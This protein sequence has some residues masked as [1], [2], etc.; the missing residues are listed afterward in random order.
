MLR[1]TSAPSFRVGDLTHGREIHKPSF[2]YKSAMIFVCGPSAGRHKHKACNPAL[3]F[4]K[5]FFARLSL[6]VFGVPP[7]ACSHV[8]LCL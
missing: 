6:A 7:Y 3:E 4:L 2:P 5:I 8:L 1:P